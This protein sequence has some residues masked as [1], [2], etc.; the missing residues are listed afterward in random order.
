M[1]Q[2]KHPQEVFVPHILM[3]LIAAAV[4]FFVQILRCALAKVRH[5]SGV[6]FLKVSGVAL[7]KKNRENEEC[8]G[9]IP[10]GPQDSSQKSKVQVEIL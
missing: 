8:L 2:Q 1:G 7:T 3:E 6:L 4:G 10:P 9:S 5:V